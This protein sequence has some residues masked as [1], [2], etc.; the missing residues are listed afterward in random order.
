MKL[1]EPKGAAIIV[2][3]CHSCEGYRGVREPNVPTITAAVRGIFAEDKILEG[4]FYTL[5][6]R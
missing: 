1:V 5:V 2:E 6:G 3:A 4:K